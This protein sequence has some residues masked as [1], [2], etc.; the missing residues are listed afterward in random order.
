MPLI[1]VGDKHFSTLEGMSSVLDLFGEEGIVYYNRIL[2]EYTDERAFL[3]D[4]KALYSDWII[5]QNDLLCAIDQVRKNE[6]A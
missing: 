2:N 3:E 6:Q 4:C 5:I 1:A